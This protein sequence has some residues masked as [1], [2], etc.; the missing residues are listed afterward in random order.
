MPKL[1][2][3]ASDAARAISFS[4]GASVREILEGAG[5][6]IRA[7][8]RGDGSCGLCLVQIEAGE[9]GPLTK[10]ESLILSPEQMA[11]HLRLACQIL[12]QSD[13][14]LRIINTVSKFTWRD[15]APECL[16]CGPS[17][18]APLAIGQST[19]TAY[20]LAIDLGTTQISLALWDLKSGR[21]MFSRIGPNP[22][23]LYGTDVVTR[24]IAAGE[25]PESARRLAHL[26]LEAIAEALETCSPPNAPEQAGAP[27]AGG[28]QQEI[29]QAAIVGNTAMLSLL[30]EADSQQLLQPHN[31]TCAK[32]YKVERL[33]SWVELLGIHPRATVDVIAPLAGFVGSDL[34]AG[35]LATRLT[36]Q[37]GS[38]LID[39]GTNSEMALWDGQTLWVTSAAGGPAFESCGMQCGMPAE[40]GAIY[41]FAGAQGSSDLH[42]QVLGGGEA[43]GFCGS[44]LVDLIACLRESGELTST[45]GFAP[46]QHK[47]GYAVPRT[48]PV[49]RLTK[50]DVDTFQRAKAAIGTGVSTML[51]RAG[52]AASD[53][54]RICVCGVFGQ[55][56]NVRNA[57]RIG[58][59]PESPP[60]RV[61]LCGNT[62]LAGCEHL[63]LSPEKSLQMVSLR[64][65]AVVI[66]LCQASDFDTRFLE[67]LYLQPLKGLNT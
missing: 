34:L 39:F 2:L 54:T 11:Q 24:L 1:T 42:F 7:G 61:E 58:L 35:V 29:V 19:D 16:P 43:R 40:P 20:G 6:L 38:L 64:E 48:D 44:G 8:C 56:L 5:I 32:E 27:R 14:D 37:R 13:L 25:S 52:M 4:P 63:L 65:R 45:G 55:N 62:A 12:P 47:D 41:H 17:F 28:R 49:I 21:R 10:T 22:Q 26:P 30:T 57:Q 51:A 67:N 66:N 50:K 15:L 23:S 36:E 3:I 60:E 46:G 53:L 33:Q 59:L 18:P 9:A 31:W